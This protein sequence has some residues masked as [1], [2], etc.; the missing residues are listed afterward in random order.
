MTIKAEYLTRYKL[1]V[2]SI[3]SKGIKSGNTSSVPSLPNVP[4]RV[5]GCSCSLMLPDD[6]LVLLFVYGFQYERDNVK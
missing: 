1:T 5:D 4:D 3:T 2:G 6:V